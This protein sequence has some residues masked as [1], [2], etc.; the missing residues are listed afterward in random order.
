[1]RTLIAAKGYA[2]TSVKN[3]VAAAGVSRRCFYEQFANSEDCF[4]T[5]LDAL[6]DELKAQMAEALKPT[7]I[8]TRRRL[9]ALL[10]P[11]MA[12]ATKDDGGLAL[13]VEAVTA[14]PA[15]SERIQMLTNRVERMLG[16]ALFLAG[17]SMLTPLLLKGVVA[18]VQ[19]VAVT[20]AREQG[21]EAL[22]CLKKELVAWILALN[23]PHL[24]ALGQPSQ[25]RA[26]DPAAPRP[27]PGRHTS[28]FAGQS[29]GTGL[30]TAVL[31]GALRVAA[32][33]HP[34]GLNAMTIADG[35]GVSHEDVLALFP[36][37][38]DCLDA[39]TEMLASE[40][41]ETVAG[42]SRVQVT[43]FT[44]VHDAVTALVRYV[45]MTASLGAHPAEVISRSCADDRAVALK[46]ELATRLFAAAACDGVGETV[47]DATAGAIW[48][49]VHSRAGR[50]PA[51]S[52]IVVDQL[53]YLVLAPQIGADAAV[54]EMRGNG[55]GAPALAAGGRS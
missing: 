35:A 31:W 51:H 6:G 16:G 7:E 14:T 5:I 41:I 39:A 29:P 37:P 30:R 10:R 21:T 45:A 44:A 52:P 4:L 1:M 28:G 47:R 46:R 11:F 12:L 22:A 48:A 54:A 36:D 53:T 27:A 17:E 8:E 24:L 20:R 33:R 34:D 25:P 49:V 23:S 15:T 40:L 18:G 9:D 43:P 32:E 42:P 38:Q 50:S 19:H 26:V 55:A 13:L 3:I 2:E